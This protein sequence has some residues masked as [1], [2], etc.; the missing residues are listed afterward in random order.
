MSH[1]LLVCFLVRLRQ[2]TGDTRTQTILEQL[3]FESIGGSA[4]MSSHAQR[5][6]EKREHPEHVVCRPH[7][8]CH[9]YHLCS[10]LDATLSAL[11]FLE[12]AFDLLP[13]R[14]L[15]LFSTLVLPCLF[16]DIAYLGEDTDIV[17][18]HA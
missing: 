6:Q 15:E 2:F 17:L 8:G 7:D 13:Q 10:S 11:L 9:G 5:E 12:L 16:D 14:L 18:R 1:H 3:I 4:H